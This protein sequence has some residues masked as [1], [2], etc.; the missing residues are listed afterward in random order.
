MAGLDN[1][2]LLLYHYD[3]TDAST[4]ITDASGNGLNGTCVNQAQLDTA[5]FKFGNASLLLDGSDHITVGSSALFRFVTGDF[6]VDYQAYYNTYG[7]HW[8]FDFGYLTNSSLV[9]FDA[10]AGSGRLGFKIGATAY[11]T[12]HTP[13]TGAWIHIALVRSSGIVRIYEAG[14]RMGVARTITTGIDCTNVT[15]WIGDYTG[16][17]GY[18]LNG[19]MDELRISNIAR[20]NSDTFVPPV[21]AYSRDDTSSRRLL[22]GG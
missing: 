19:W 22:V 21:S 6:T 16:E 8:D 17:V 18:G 12:G 1:Y 14:S 15:K 7:Y 5:K 3:G 13:V 9:I 2:T 20:W 4:T 11:S 10:S